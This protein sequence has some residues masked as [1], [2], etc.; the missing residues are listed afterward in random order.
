MI[1][2][3]SLASGHQPCAGIGFRAPHFAEIVTTRP[4]IG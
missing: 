2:A 1:M 3:F 4:A